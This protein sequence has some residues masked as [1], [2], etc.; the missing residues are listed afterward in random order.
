MQHRKQSSSA[1]S[2][3]ISLLPGYTWH[4]SPSS[5]RCTRLC[6]TLGT[7]EL[8]RRKLL[9]TVRIPAHLRTSDRGMEQSTVNR[10]DLASMHGVGE[11]APLVAKPPAGERS[12]LQRKAQ[13]LRAA[14]VRICHLPGVPAPTDRSRRRSAHCVECG[15][16]LHNESTLRPHVVRNADSP[17]ARFPWLVRPSGCFVA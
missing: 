13:G 17:L 11:A 2:S 14:V 5:R 12:P 15:A 4:P 3:R 10:L 16:I 1:S 9:Y 7:P 6:D 8:C